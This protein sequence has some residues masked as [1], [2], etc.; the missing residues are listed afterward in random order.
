MAPSCKATSH[1]V[2]ILH[3][4]ATIHK[5]QD[6]DMAIFDPVLANLQLDRVPSF[7]LDIRKRMQTTKGIDVGLHG[8]LQKE[9]LWGA[10]HILFI[11]KF[12]DDAKWLLKIPATGH[13]NQFD[14]AAA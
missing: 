2:N 3:E 9:P 11:I 13:S 14:T 6:E 1:E 5:E 10:F 4:E 8:D 12:T 7:V